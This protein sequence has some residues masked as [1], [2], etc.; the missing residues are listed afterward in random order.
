MFQKITLFLFTGTEASNLVHYLDWAIASECTPHKYQ[1]VN[2]CS[3]EQIQSK[4]SNRN[5]ATEKLDARLKNKTWNNPQ[6]NT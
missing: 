1:L 6:I 4:R 5:M 2:I 3:W